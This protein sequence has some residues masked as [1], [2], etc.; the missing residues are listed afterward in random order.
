MKCFKCQMIKL[1]KEFPMDKI[2]E[3]CNHISTWCL[4]C[5]ITH[6]RIKANCPE[7]SANL[8]IEEIN[9]FKIAWENASFK[10]GSLFQNSDNTCSLNDEK[11]QKGEIF[12]FLFNGEYLVFKLEDIQTVKELKTVLAGK[13]DVN[14]SC[15]M[16]LYKGIEL[17]VY[18]QVNQEENKLT[19]YGIRAGDCIQLLIMK[20]RNLSIINLAFDLYWKYPLTG[21]DNFLDGTCFLYNGNDLLK[22]YD[23]KNK[24]DPVY[25]CIKHSGYIMDDVNSQGH[26]IITINLSEFPETINKIYFTL[27]SQYSN[28]SSFSN[29]SFKLYNEERPEEQVVTYNFRTAANSQAVIMCC[30]QRSH[31]GSWALF[32]IGR[33]SKGNAK[34]YNSINESIKNLGFDIM[35][36]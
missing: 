14:S 25:P 27:S 1:S 5:L 28:L 16:L 21:R 36:N 13:I 18:Q 33:L 35:N 29:L 30:V 6:L 26:Q 31:D 3:R 4:K 2:T 11:A 10:I 23:N 32:E 20:D 8:N 24:F 15:L 12:V 22:I 7:C 34:D 9:K 19:A 17:K